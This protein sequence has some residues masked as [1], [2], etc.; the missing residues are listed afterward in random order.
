MELS[1]SEQKRRIKQIEILAEELASF[2]SALVEQLPV[3][4]E[5]RGLLHEAAALG[6]NGARKRHIKYI[7]KLL[8]E[9]ALEPLY[10]FVSE[11]K[12]KELENK[13]EQHEIEY[14]R[15]SLIDE[16]ITSRRQAKAQQEEFTEHWPSRCIEEITAQLPGVDV[17]ELRR[18]SFLFAMSRNKRYSRELFRLLE[19]AQGHCKRSQ[20]LTGKHQ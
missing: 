14:L 6:P 8:R 4:L 19:A 9:E 15:D 17:Q 20:R 16:A 13:K 5:I 2:S 3:S 11:R 12:G 10:A 1:R 18:L 7:T